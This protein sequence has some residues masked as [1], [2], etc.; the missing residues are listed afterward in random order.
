MIFQEVNLLENMTQCVARKALMMSLFS[1]EDSY[2]YYI[3]N[4]ASH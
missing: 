4:T 1:D 2:E 3:C